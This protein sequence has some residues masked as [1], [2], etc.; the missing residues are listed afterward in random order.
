V[1]SER[2]V[3]AN[4]VNARA[5]TGPRTAAGKARAARN[6]QRHGLTLSVL[7]D[8]AYADELKAYAKELVGDGTSAELQHLA[9]RVAAAQIDLINVRQARHHLISSALKSGGRRDADGSSADGG[10][11]TRP[12]TIRKGDMNS[13]SVPDALTGQDAQRY[14]E[15]LAELAAN[16]AGMDRYERRALSRR[17][18]AI[19]ELDQARAHA[20]QSLE[21]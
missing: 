20:S 3:S 2:K 14:A 16:M 6:A 18:T 13:T 21:S 7:A 11:L 15:I 8:P 1:I 5:S 17:K 12:R 10:P 19:R 9:C 4:R